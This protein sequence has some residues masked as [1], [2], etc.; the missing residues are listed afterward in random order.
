MKKLFFI[1][2][3][4]SIYM[5]NLVTNAG[6][7]TLNAS[8]TQLSIYAQST[9]DSTAHLVQSSVALD[10]ACTN[11]RAYILFS[12]KELFATAL[13]ASLQSKA[14]NFIYE[15]EAES[16]SAGGHQSSTCKV[17]SIWW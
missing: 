17:I 8:S 13:A 7:A 12:D 16:K 10:G 9:A 14:V 11:N 6:A 5:Y 2:I 15:T 1:G 3:F 4:A